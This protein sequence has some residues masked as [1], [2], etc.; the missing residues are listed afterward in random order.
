[1]SETA[2]HHAYV[3]RI[4]NGIAVLLLGEE[5]K[6]RLSL[7]RRYLPEGA[8]EGQALI[9]TLAIDAEGTKTARAETQSLID[10]LLKRSQG[11]Q[12]GLGL[13]LEGDSK[14]GAEK[15]RPSSHSLRQG[16]RTARIRKEV[17]S[18][19]ITILPAAS[20]ERWLRAARKPIGQGRRANRALR[21][22]HPVG[23]AS[24]APWYQRLIIPH[25]EGGQ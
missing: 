14:R 22:R 2:R 1:M 13:F 20:R 3:D 16:P 23:L 15:K 25:I 12:K 7:P 9:L 4:E 18:H 11:E 24:I 5:E 8:R 21:A 17:R 19:H 10:D 6:D